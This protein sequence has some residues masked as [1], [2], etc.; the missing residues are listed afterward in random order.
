[1]TKSIILLSAGLDSLTSL[2]VAKNEYNVQ[3]AISF[4]YGQRAR[5]QEIENSKKIAKFYE[6]EHEIIKLDWLS[7][8][9]KTAL[10]NKDEELPNPD[11][12][13]LDDYD[14]SIKTAK[15][16]WVPNRNGLFLNI[17]ASFADA[18]DFTHI[19]FGANKEEGTTFPD[20]T[21]DFIDS[22]NKSFEYSTLIKP[23]VL[24]PLIRYDKIDIVKLAVEHDV[25][26]EFLR[27]CYTS[28][29]KHCGKC[30]S[31]QRLRRAIYENGYYDLEEKLFETHE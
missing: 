10:V 24:A 23:I 4:D 29:S 25:P 8:I 12:E 2:A 17:A 20:N 11:F 1:M 5:K 27:S 3:L 7:D 26:F 13:Q 21:Q 28:E 14:E 16:V 19:I 9:T 22:I 18:N 31:C 15:S 30:E 6:I